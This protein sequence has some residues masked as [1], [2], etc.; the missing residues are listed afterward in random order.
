MLESNL[1]DFNIFINFN[2]QDIS[3]YERKLLKNIE[4]TT[5]ITK[6]HYYGIKRYL[7]KAQLFLGV[8]LT[9]MRKFV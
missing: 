7:Q 3:Q 9:V 6:K 5:D 8:V 4:D 1:E 2:E